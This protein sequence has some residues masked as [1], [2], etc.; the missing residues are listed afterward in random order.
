MF[1]YPMEFLSTDHECMPDMDV[2]LKHGSVATGIIRELGGSDWESI[3][4]KGKKNIM[5]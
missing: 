4:R 5:D 2:V 1:I 3:N